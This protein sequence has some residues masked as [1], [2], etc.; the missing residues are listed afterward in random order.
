MSEQSDTQPK[1]PAGLRETLESQIAIQEPPPGTLDDTAEMEPVNVRTPARP[2]LLG[3][4]M[5][6]MVCICATLTG[7]ASLAGYRDGVATS[8][9]RQTRTMATE[10]ALQY[11]TGVA[12]LQSG[13][14]ALAA[15]R[16][17]WIETLQPPSQY[18]RDSGTLLPMAQT[19]SVDMLVPTWQSQY[20]TSV[21]YLN[22]GNVMPAIQG[23]DWILRSVEAAHAPASY[24]QDSA[25]LLATAWI[26]ASYT[27]TSIAP[28][29][30]NT[31]APTAATATLGPT[32]TTSSELTP[33]VN[34][35]DPAYMYQQA[36][37]AMRLAD[38]E[39]AIEWLDT[40]TSLDPTY[41]A[42]EVRGKLLEALTKQAEIYLRGMNSDGA[43]QLARGI[44]LSDRAFAM[45]DTTTA[46]EADVAKR[47]LNARSLVAAGNY[48]DALVILEG[49]CAESATTCQWG[50]QGVTI[51]SLL[52][53]ARSGGG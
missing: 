48:V 26:M 39:E 11:A 30:T 44:L 28:A 10:I 35:L 40:L 46:Y 41:N 9:A 20:A 6:S 4:V 12:N 50:Y 37:R 25:D 29:A 33:T 47:F 42:T 31:S 34:A 32:A 16:F 8:D 36:E 45:G 43:D 18:R 19:M 22:S 49:L 53:Q 3:I 24:A 7:L 1:A 51:S 5:F 14:P 52:E 2:L 17:G 23:F 21:A 13:Y 15:E 38:Y 27:P